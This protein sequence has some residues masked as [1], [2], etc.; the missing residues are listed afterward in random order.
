MCADGMGRQGLSKAPLG[1]LPLVGEP[2]RSICV[3]IVGPIEP[4]STR[5][6]RYIVTIVDMATRFQ[7]AILLKTITAEEVMEEL[8]KF[9]C[10][11]GIPEKIQTDRGSQ[12]T[13]DLMVRVNR[14]LAIKHTFSRN[15]KWCS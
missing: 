4:R 11:M 13:A 15:R 6:Y 14:L 10:R 7:E 3:D 9:Y 1:H 2:F 8:F 5:G 12:F